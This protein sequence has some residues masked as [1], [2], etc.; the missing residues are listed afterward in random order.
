MPP[1]SK[2]SEGR[3]SLKDET[4]S[5]VHDNKTFELDNSMPE[6]LDSKIHDIKTK[7]DSIK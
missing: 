7:L 6:D 2:V 4:I 1:S 5:I 3:G